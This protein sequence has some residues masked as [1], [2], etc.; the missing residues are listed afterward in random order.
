M[1][2]SLIDHGRRL[3]VTATAAYRIV[4]SPPLA[5]IAASPSIRGGDPSSPECKT[6]PESWNKLRID[7]KRGATDHRRRGSEHGGP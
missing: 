6:S 3:T 1:P 2:S 7:D 4:N 5:S